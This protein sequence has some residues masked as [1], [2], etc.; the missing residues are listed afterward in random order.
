MKRCLI[1]VDYQ[2]DFVD[3]SL[4]FDGAQL[5]EQPII[6]KIREYHNNGD[7]VVF[8]FDTHNENYLETLEGKYLPIKHCLENTSGH[9]LYGKVAEEV[10]DTDKTF[11][12][13]CFGSGELYEYLKT[14]KFKSIELIGLVSNI[15]VLANAVLAKTAQ[16]E[17]NVIVDSHCTAGFDARLH[18][19]AV[20]VMKGLQVEVV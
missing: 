10:K 14:E 12:K 20:D 15:C 16:P 7:E 18:E 2:N 13:N 9:E 17:T 6:G 3:G 11:N 8:T 4:G 1:V 19:A 5:L